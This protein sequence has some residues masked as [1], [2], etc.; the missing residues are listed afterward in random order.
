VLTAS[1]VDVD[2]G[3]RQPEQRE[4]E[5]DAVAVAGEGVTVEAD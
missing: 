2:G 1:E 3:E 5:L 4:E